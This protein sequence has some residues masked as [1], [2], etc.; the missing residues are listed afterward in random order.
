MA[1]QALG[2]SLEALLDGD[3]QGKNGSVA[4]ASRPAAIPG[5]GVRSLLRGSQS[6]T[7]IATP[8]PPSRMPRWYLFGGDI[9]L[10]A[11]AVGIGLSSRHPLSAGRE[12]FC[13]AVVGLGCLLSLGAVWSDDVSRA[14][15]RIMAHGKAPEQ[16]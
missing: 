1:K 11:L 7:A 6:A 9:L 14:G 3:T 13:V 10:V 8:I 16:F 2:R 5:P 15:A 12:V 4:A